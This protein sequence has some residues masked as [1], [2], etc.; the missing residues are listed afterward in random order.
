MELV[1]SLFILFVC[2][3]SSHG[4]PSGCR[5][6]DC[7]GPISSRIEPRVD[8]SY[9]RYLT[10][11]PA[12]I[13]QDVRILDLK[14]NQISS[15][16]AANISHFIHLKKLYL[17][18]NEIQILTETDLNRFI[19]LESLHLDLNQLE[20]LHTYSLNRL[21]NLR[22]VTLS[23]NLIER[24]EDN[25]FINLSK[26]E[27]LNLYYNRIQ[28]IGPDTF[29]GLVSL[30][31]LYLSWNDITVIPDETFSSL[32][33]L[34]RLYI[35]HNMIQ[36]I[37]ADTF[38]GLSSLKWLHLSHNPSL[39]ISERALFHTPGL[40]HLVIDEADLTEIPDA[41][42]QLMVSLEYLSLESNFISDIPLNIIDANFTNL[43]RLSFWNNSITE[44][45]AKIFQNIGTLKSIN[46]GY[47]ELT[48]LP[49]YVFPNQTED[50]IL[51]GNRFQ[52]DCHLQWFNA[53]INDE[54]VDIDTILCENPSYVAMKDLIADLGPEDLQCPPEGIQNVHLIELVGKT[55]QVQCPL[56][57]LDTTLN[58]TWSSMD[59]DTILLVSNDGNLLFENPQRNNSGTY[60]CRAKNR[61]GCVEIEVTID[62][63]DDLHEKPTDRKND[64]IPEIP[65]WAI[66]VI[67]VSVV[68]CSCCLPCFV[69]TVGAWR[70]RKRREKHEQHSSNSEDDVTSTYKIT[71][72]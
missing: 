72:F 12:K 32:A 49:E 2:L 25:S 26:L 16:T 37:T 23:K 3:L 38:F 13:P 61:A 15:L 39:F 70:R 29:R 54:N 42:K 68:T 50:L 20:T 6:Y 14:G 66:L 45:R 47:N 40:T 7:D 35:S 33:T 17:Q 5:C 18:S 28:S 11:A 27:V 62:F 59:E 44:L 64:V 22:E 69:F 9:L 46:L 34:E 56:K 57:K 24:I 1:L 65:T 71:S 36:T 8:C 51:D 60:F 63:V 4:C 21:I 67:C 55:T 43:R 53:W 41:I 31:R 52:C 58:I 48:S 10:T 19:H 30:R